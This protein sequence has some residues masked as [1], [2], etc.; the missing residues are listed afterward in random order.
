MSASD[1]KV[2]N[3]PSVDKVLIFLTTWPEER[4]YCLCVSL[5]RLYHWFNGWKAIKIV[6]VR[7]AVINLTFCA[8]KS[9]LKNCN[10]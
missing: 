3:D 2:G 1:P 8:R 10:F 4:H 7:L 6:Y 9:F 5:V